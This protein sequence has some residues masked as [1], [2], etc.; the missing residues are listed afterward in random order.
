MGRGDGIGGRERNKV[1]F[2]LG[3]W[4]KLMRIGVGRKI[5][6]ADCEGSVGCGVGSDVVLCVMDVTGGTESLLSV[7]DSSFSV[8]VGGMGFI[9][10]DGVGN[11]LVWCVSGVT[12]N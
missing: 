11:G 1:S 7:S 8:D 10:L 12:W 4:A 3:S 6:G 2:G 9:L 5:D